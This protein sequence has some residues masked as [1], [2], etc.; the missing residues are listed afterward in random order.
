M[1]TNIKRHSRSVVSV[2]LAVCLLVSCLTVGIIA[3]NAAYIGGSSKA[4]DNVKANT[5]DVA[6]SADDA[7]DTENAAVGAKAPDAVGAKVDSDSVGWT[8]AKC[9]VH[10]QFDGGSWT[11]AS[12]N[13]ST[14]I[15]SIT[16]TKGGV[17]NFDLVAEDWWYKGKSGNSSINSVTTDSSANYYA[18]YSNSSDSGNKGDRD[19]TV[20]LP[21]AGTYNF[22]YVTRTKKG[23]QENAE[24]QF[25]FWKTNTSYSISYNSPTNGS[26]TTK[27]T[28]GT[29]GNTIT[30]VATP[31]T[32]YQIASYSVKKTSDS[33]AVTAS[34]SGN[35]ITFTM[36]SYNVTVNVTFS[37]VNYTITKSA[38]NC[39]ITAPATATYGSTVNVTVA[40]DTNY[41]LKTFTVKQGSTNVSTTS[42]GTNAYSFTMPAGNVTITANCTTTVGLV[43]FKFKSAT[44]YV[45][46][47]FISVNG[48]PEVEMTLGSP[49]D[50]L[51]QGTKDSRV[52]PKSDT[53][54]LRYAWYTANMTGIDTSKPVT[55]TVRGQDTYMEAVTNLTPAQRDFYDTPLNM[56]DD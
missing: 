53:G 39:T 17:L 15:M 40:P 21:S 33:S 38:S 12:M 47:P 7:V 27:P 32:G 3:T 46:H 1:K 11:D 9:Y 50:Y 29:Q 20:T 51:D 6:N 22:E 42:T 44:A 30:V 8:A 18:W 34:R 56:I 48:G 31:N 23:D 37:Q 52:K 35:T 14:G 45:Y 43:S 41:A 5:A 16:T 13:S 19:Y 49:V 25:H 28:T 54:S 26:F 55:V 36:P 2:V 10:Y 24:L 4:A